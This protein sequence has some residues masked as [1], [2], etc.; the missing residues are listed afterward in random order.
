MGAYESGTAVP[1][2]NFAYASQFGSAGNGNGQFTS[3]V[4]IAIDPTSHNFVVV[5]A[6]GNRVQIFSSAGVYLSQFGSPGQRQWTIR[7]PTHR[8]DRS[9]EPTTSL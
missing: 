5:D 8:R 1:F 9:D 2:T 4:G 7:Y 6:V 3:P